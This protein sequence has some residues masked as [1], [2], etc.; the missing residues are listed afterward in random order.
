MHRSNRI[1]AASREN[2]EGLLC[3]T[4]AI[5]PEWREPWGLGPYS[6]R[7]S[8]KP[9]QQAGVLRERSALTKPASVAITTSAR[10][11]SSSAKTNRHESKDHLLHYRPQ[12]WTL[13]QRG[14]PF[15]IN[16]ISTIE[17]LSTAP[18]AACTSSGPFTALPLTR[19]R[20]SPTLIPAVA[21]ALCGATAVTT[22]PST[23]SNPKVLT[24]IVAVTT[25]NTAGPL[26]ITRTGLFSL[27]SLGVTFGPA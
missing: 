20:M 27:A 17:P 25:P 23:P 16:R 24:G 26:A 22:A 11:K 14:N 19:S 18:I 21:P 4:T 1:L 10:V 9:M 13:T 7:R 3:P 12:N 6:V 2:C 15:R 5:R 8:R